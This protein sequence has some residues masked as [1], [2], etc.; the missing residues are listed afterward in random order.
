[1]SVR[2]EDKQF[3]NSNTPDKHTAVESNKNQEQKP[4][5]LAITEPEHSLDPD[6]VNKPIQV[7]SKVPVSPEVEY[8]PVQTMEVSP[9]DQKQDHVVKAVKSV[10]D[11]TKQV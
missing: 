7:K 5:D 9:T 6:I 3:S 10:A 1:M 4:V 2:V 11:A 8:R